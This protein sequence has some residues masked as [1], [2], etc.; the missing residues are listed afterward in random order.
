ME[1]LI[2]KRFHSVALKILETAL[3][4]HSNEFII[5]EQMSK[6]YILMANIK[7]ALSIIH[8]FLQDNPNSVEA[9]MKIGKIK[10]FNILLTR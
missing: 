6:C 2:E 1:E 9:H 4:L 5:Y 7:D 10:F 3:I 8:K